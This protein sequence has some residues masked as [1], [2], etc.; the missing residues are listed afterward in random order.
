ML[1]TYFIPLERA[2]V[3]QVVKQ[4]SKLYDYLKR[5]GSFTASNGWVVT[6]QV[7]PE[8][9]L[10]SKT[11][12]LRGG[13]TAKDLR[14]HRCWDLSNNENRTKFMTEINQALQELTNVV[15]GNVPQ[16]VVG[17]DVA[18]DFV[19]PKATKKTNQVN[20]FKHMVTA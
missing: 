9:N 18:F 15:A 20:H 3:F 6:S 13:N 12:F 11:I 7:A 16:I 4:S 2:F 5:N 1:S 8:I 19:A 17:V 14:I 10:L